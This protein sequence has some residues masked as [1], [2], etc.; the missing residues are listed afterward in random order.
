MT[1]LE[2]I[3]P[4]VPVG[5]GRLSY[6]GNGR[7]VHSNAKRLKPWRAK[8]AAHIREQMTGDG[9][10]ID[11]PVKV[12]ITFTM[13]RP[14]S[15]PRR[16]WPSVRPDLDH[17]GRAALDAITASGAIKDDAQVVMLGLTKCCGSQPG[18]T[19]TLRPMAVSHV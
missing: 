6:V 19:L 2:V 13:P 12:A 7:V 10:P 3:V 17:L 16:V 5:Q 15:A 1:V 11:G 4:G 18:M 14:K 9:W 8:V